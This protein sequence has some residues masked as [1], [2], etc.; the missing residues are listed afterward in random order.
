MQGSL[1]DQAVSCPFASQAPARSALFQP[2]V[3][4]RVCKPDTKEEKGPGRRA[5]VLERAPCP[6][7][8]RG[9]TQ[10]P[11]GQGYFGECEEGV[12]FRNKTSL[13]LR[14]RRQRPPSAAQRPLLGPRRGAREGRGPYRETAGPRSEG[15]IRPPPGSPHFV[16]RTQLHG[17]ITTCNSKHAFL[18][19][20]ATPVRE[21]G[22]RRS[23]Y[24]EHFL[25]TASGLLN[26][27]SGFFRAL[28]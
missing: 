15:R 20:K 28:C 3:P 12:T 13:S 5:Q 11:R 8:G 16:H 21:N 14:P 19:S 22:F 18:P 6:Q 7:P 10:D 1:H 4:S 9:Q 25:M 27:A 24:S 2:Q 17:A 23:P 26:T